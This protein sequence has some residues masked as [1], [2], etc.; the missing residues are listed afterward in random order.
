MKA[1]G[2]SPVP[3]A[4]HAIFRYHETA[5]FPQNPVRFIQERLVVRRVMKDIQV[6]NDIITL[7]IYWQHLTIEQLKRH[8]GLIRIDNIQAKYVT[9]EPLPKQLAEVTAP[10]SYIQ[11]LAPLGNLSLYGTIIEFRPCFLDTHRRTLQF[12][13][14]DLSEFHLRL[15][16]F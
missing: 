9:T 4:I 15:S 6:K 8:V 3:N 11:H 5:V 14:N 7:R 13:G 2:E 1:N 12:G 10:R 16:S